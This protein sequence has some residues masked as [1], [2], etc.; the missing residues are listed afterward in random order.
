M[1]SK[2]RNILRKKE[3]KNKKRRGTNRTKTPCKTNVG[4]SFHSSKKKLNYFV[5][6]Y[7]TV[8]PTK[9]YCRGCSK[10][11]YIQLTSIHIKNAYCP[12]CDTLIPIPD[13]IDNNSIFT[14]RYI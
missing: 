1:S 6:N 10:D 12:S 2:L 7:P 8:K 14:G 11:F 4:R 13:L 3:I 9:I 5:D